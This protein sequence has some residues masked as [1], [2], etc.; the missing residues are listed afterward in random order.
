MWFLIVRM[1]KR[2]GH[3]GSSADGVK[4]IV[5]ISSVTAKKF[6]TR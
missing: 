3:A 5:K 4:K 1:E 2:G 6:F